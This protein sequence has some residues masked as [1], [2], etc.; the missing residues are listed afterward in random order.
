M[1]L[2]KSNPGSFHFQEIRERREKCISNFKE[3]NYPLQT[4]MNKIMFYSNS[5]IDYIFCQWLCWMEWDKFILFFHWDPV[6]LSYF[7]ILWFMALVHIHLFGKEKHFLA[8]FHLGM[9]TLGSLRIQHGFILF[10][11]HS[12]FQ[13]IL[14]KEMDRLVRVQ[15]LFKR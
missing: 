10:K 9:L 2:Q 7:Q 3:K 5:I 4:S 1:H 15:E 14:F 6:T 12:Q 11:L 8:F 13:M